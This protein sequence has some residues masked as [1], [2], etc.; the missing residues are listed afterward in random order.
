MQNQK[1]L[2]PQAHKSLAQQKMNSAHNSYRVE[3]LV[4][5][6]GPTDYERGQKFCIEAALTLTSAQ[7]KQMAQFKT[8]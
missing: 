2:L 5:G 4:V 1:T 3:A 8:S 6:T 7:G